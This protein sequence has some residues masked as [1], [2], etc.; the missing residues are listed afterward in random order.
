MLSKSQYLQGIQCQKSLWLQK[1]KHEISDKPNTQ[2]QSIF[3]TGHAV[4]SIATQLL[5][6]GVEIERDHEDFDGMIQKTQDLINQGV[7]TIYEATFKEKGVFV[8]ID[9]LH[10]GDYGWEIYEVKSSTQLKSY[11]VDDASSQWYAL[12]QVLD[13]HKIVIVYINNQ[14]VRKGDLNIHK[15]FIIDDITDQVVAKQSYVKQNLES[16]EAMLKGTMPG[17]GIGTHCSEPNECD[18]HSYCWK[19]IPEVSIFNLYLMRSNKKYELYR[20]GIVRLEDIPADYELTDK[21]KIQVV[22]SLKNEVYINKDVLSNFLDKLVYPLSFFDFETFQNAIPRFDGQRPYMQMP[23]QYSLHILNDMGEMS[24]NE[25]LGDENSDPRRALC[26]KMLEDI[27]PTGTILAFN[28][29]FEIMCINDLA[30]DFP[31]FSDSLTSLIDRFE[32]LI[33][34]FRG[35]GYYHPAFNGSFSIKSVLPAMFPNDLELDY[36]SLSIQDGGMAM[37]TFAKLHEI[38]DPDE[39]KIIRQDLLAYC[40]L[41]TLAMVK[42]WEKLSSLVS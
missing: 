23:F 29:S 18:F 24:H 17:M 1:R 21:Q 42:I 40:H 27:P 14:Y 4:G 12:N 6:G 8:M 30:R 5:P 15:L 41:D 13:L 28:K 32:D 19:H 36:K 20:Q 35:E 22:A 2:A 33:E 7:E 26:E 9:I 25:F 37:N 38:E 39:V 11:Y 3:D 31:E 10:K 16:M 34:P